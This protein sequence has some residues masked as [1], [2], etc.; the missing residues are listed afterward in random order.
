MNGSNRLKLGLVTIIDRLIEQLSLTSCSLINDIAV[1]GISYHDDLIS[2]SASKGEICRAQQVVIALPPRVALRDIVFSPSLASIRREELST[3]STWMA[4]HAKAV[5][6]Y[7]KAFWRNKGL[8]GDVYNQIGPLSEIHD[9]SLYDKSSAAL[10]GFFST[11][12]I[13]RTQKGEKLERLLVK[14]LVRIF[15]A[16]ASHPV[17]VLYKD[18]ASDL[19]TATALDQHAL[20]H[21]PLNELSNIIEAGWSKNLIWSGTETA[22]GHVNGYLEGAVQS[23]LECVDIIKRKSRSN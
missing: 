18:W 23:S 22:K 7:K 13:Q 4:G 11:P 16:A 10:V 1:T 2:V 14:Q 17:A 20:N 12:P 3:I 21:H 15:G 8:S 9:A 6:V 5:I 19:N